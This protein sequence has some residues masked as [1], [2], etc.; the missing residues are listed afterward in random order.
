MSHWNA[1]SAILLTRH[2]KLPAIARP[3]EQ[4]GLTVT[5][6]SSFDTDRLGTF[7]REI[8]RFAGQRETALEKAKIASEQGENRIGLGSEGAFGGGLFCINLE[9]VCLFDQKHG[10]TLYGEHA[11]PFGLEQASV[12][13]VEEL[14]RFM[15]RCPTG[16]GLVMRPEHAGHPDI[17]KGLH[18]Q[19]EINTRF[20]AL[21][22][23]SASD[24]F[25]SNT[26][27]AHIILQVEWPTLALLQKISE[28]KWKACV[29]VVFC[30]ASG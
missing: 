17:H 16:Q 11:A 13:S 29:P 6:D 22:G 18:H 10:L 5:C 15:D 8:E 25:S 1:R 30:P 28:P 19:H 3:L 2:G 14:K 21:R 23:N 9:I 12:S 4:L 7:T 27:F 26:T 20:R 24:R